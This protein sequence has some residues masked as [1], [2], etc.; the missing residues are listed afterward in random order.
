[1]AIIFTDLIITYTK[2]NCHIL[3]TVFP[4]NITMKNTNNNLLPSSTPDHHRAFGL[5]DVLKDEAK[6]DGQ[7]D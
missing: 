7:R 5:Y 2:S 6:F 3:L 1:M 4:G